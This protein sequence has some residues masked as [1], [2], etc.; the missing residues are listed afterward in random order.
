MLAV[1]KE[2][3]LHA[4]ENSPRVRDERQGVCGGLICL[5]LVNSAESYPDGDH[6]A[7]EKRQQC[8][9]QNAVSNTRDRGRLREGLIISCFD[10]LGHP[11]EQP[12]LEQMAGGATYSTFA[13][14]ATMRRPG[15][16]NMALYRRPFSVFLGLAI[17]LVSIVIFSSLQGR[18][19]PSYLQKG[20]SMSRYAPQEDMMAD[21]EDP[22]RLSYH[23]YTPMKNGYAE[24]YVETRGPTKRSSLDMMKRSLV[25]SKLEM[26][27]MDEDRDVMTLESPSKLSMNSLSRRVPTGM[28]RMA[29]RYLPAPTMDSSSSSSSSS[30]S[31]AEDDTVDDDDTST[32]MIVEEEEGYVMETDSDDYYD[33]DYDDD[34]DDEDEDDDDYDVDDDD[35]EEDDSDYSDYSDDDEEEDDDDDYIEDNDDDDDVDVVVYESGDVGDLT[36]GMAADILD[37]VL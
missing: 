31:M 14:A 30:S 10:F 36:D 27:N 26:R 19:T 7:G 28:S 33:S 12:F 18:T 15:R 4:W 1:R 35:D 34:D 3:A 37:I 2:K 29:S 17:A 8:H 13:V 20:N 23:K 25:G 11:E 16:T 32:Q 6:E 5:N 9:C 22:K 24:T 21:P